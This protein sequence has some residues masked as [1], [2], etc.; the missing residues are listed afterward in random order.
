MPLDFELGWRV[1]ID[2]AVELG[3]E[4]RGEFAKGD[5]YKVASRSLVMLRSVAPMGRGG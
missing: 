4:P 5:S 2:T 3:Q 1:L